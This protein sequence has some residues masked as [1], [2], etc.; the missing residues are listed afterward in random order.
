MAESDCQLVADA[1]AAQGWDKPASQYQS[2]WQEQQAGKRDVLVAE[3]RGRF[4]GYVT[5]VWW[6]RSS[7]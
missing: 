3:H 7:A 6:T 2:Y 5:I 1:F 4:A